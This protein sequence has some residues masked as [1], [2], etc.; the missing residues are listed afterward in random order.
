[1][2]QTIPPLAVYVVVGAIIGFG[3]APIMVTLVSDVL[4]GPSLVRY[5]L[6]LTGAA[7]S[8]LAAFGFILAIRSAAPAVGQ[9]G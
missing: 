9:H 2:L 3:L 4:G 8:I 5:G 6:A 7:T 1:M